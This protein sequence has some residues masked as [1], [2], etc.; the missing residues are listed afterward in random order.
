MGFFPKLKGDFDEE[1]NTPNNGPTIR[2]PILG[3]AL[4]D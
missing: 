4:E 3:G 2:P 1:N